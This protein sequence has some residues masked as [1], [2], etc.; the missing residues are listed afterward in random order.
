MVR[1]GYIAHE[2]DREYESRQYKATFHVSPP[3]GASPPPA[4]VPPRHREPAP[5][6]ASGWPG[7]EAA[8]QRHADGSRGTG[9]L[10]GWGDCGQES[11]RAAGRERLKQQHPCR[12]RGGGNLST[13]HGRLKLDE[14]HAYFAVP[15]VFLPLMGG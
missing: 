2:V 12:K 3:A 9:S 4:R 14:C 8:G 11:G 6:R 13:P 7:L 5:S 10:R 1:T 15:T